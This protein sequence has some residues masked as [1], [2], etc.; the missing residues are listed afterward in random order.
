MSCAG[1]AQLVHI[2]SMLYQVTV[3]GE[4]TCQKEGEKDEKLEVLKGE[5]ADLASYTGCFNDQVALGR[6]TLKVSL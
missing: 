1:C 3:A 4:I 6:S 2:T 5:V